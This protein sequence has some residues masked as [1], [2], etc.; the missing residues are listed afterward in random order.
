MFYLK[1]LIIITFMNCIWHIRKKKEK[2]NLYRDVAQKG[3][4]C[5]LFLLVVSDQQCQ[6]LSLLFQLWENFSTDEK[7]NVFQQTQGWADFLWIYLQVLP[8]M[9]GFWLLLQYMLPHLFVWACI[10]RFLNTSG[11]HEK[12]EMKVSETFLCYGSFH[13]LF[14]WRLPG[15]NKKT[16]KPSV[17]VKT[18]AL[19]SMRNKTCQGI[20]LQENKQRWPWRVH[21]KVTPSPLTFWSHSPHLFGLLLIHYRNKP[22]EG[23]CSYKYT[24]SQPPVIG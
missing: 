6:C 23:K 13:F 15:E 1:R 3:S 21:P 7:K 8:L 18:K 11:N 9:L 22:L 4:L 24:S 19:Q 20:W 14:T 12:T 10:R 16:I 17:K 2:T 5:G